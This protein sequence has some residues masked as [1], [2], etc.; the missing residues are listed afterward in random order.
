MIVDDDLNPGL[1]QGFRR[2]QTSRPSPDDGGSSV[3]DASLYHRYG[4]RNGT[5]GLGLRAFVVEQL[6]QQA[7]LLQTTK[8]R[9]AI[10]RGLQ[11]S[12]SRH[13]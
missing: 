11:R 4:H 9:S 1:R 10:A 2:D 7:A 3:H 13:D 6:N 8:A 5:A 12:G